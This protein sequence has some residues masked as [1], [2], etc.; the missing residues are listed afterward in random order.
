MPKLIYFY[1]SDGARGEGTRVRWDINNPSTNRY[2][3]NI[4]NEGMFQMWDKLVKEGIFA[5]ACT[6]IDSMRG[7]HGQIKVTPY[8]TVYS[9][10]HLED[11]LDII[12][13]EDIIVARGGFKPWYNVLQTLQTRGNWILFYR[14]NTNRH[15]WPFWDVTL[16][17]LI[18]KPVRAA[19]RLHF[20][21]SKPTNETL[22]YPTPDRRKKY[23][24]LLNASHIHPKKGQHR[25]IKA[26]IE[27]KKLFG[28]NIS[29][30]LPGSFLRSWAREEILANIKKHSLDV[31]MPG[32]VTREQLNILYNMSRFY[33][34]IGTGGQNDRGTL[35]AMRCGLP[36]LLSNTKAFA[37]FT[38]TDIA[39]S[40]ILPTDASDTFVAQKTKG[41]LDYCRGATNL[42]ERTAKFY[43]Q[44]NGM[45]EVII[46]KM[47][48]LFNH[49]FDI[50]RP[51][52]EAILQRYG[53]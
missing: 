34:H 44:E 18:S 50:G 5:H 1:V 28:N 11:I 37:P 38:Y 4:A 42:H 49:I 39:F 6:F 21:F 16:N 52:R 35:E 14:A 23:D 31:F 46:P 32:G 10:P 24:V 33:V 2:A 12:T 15:A 40:V 17:D 25:F 45:K 43:L 19:N 47:S 30:C 9:V 13:P 41:M 27:Y 29:I 8:S 22:F 3:Q 7:R 53:V 20:N 26:A 51:D 36:V 48:K